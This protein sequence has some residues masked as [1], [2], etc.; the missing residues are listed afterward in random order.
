MALFDWRSWTIFNANSPS[1]DPVV[2]RRI[3]NAFVV[4]SGPNAKVLDV[5]GTEAGFMRRLDAIDRHRVC[6]VNPIKTR[7]IQYGFLSEVPDAEAPFALAMMFGVLMYMDTDQASATFKRTYELLAPGKSFMV[8]EPAIDTKLGAVDH[9]MRSKCG[10]PSRRYTQDAIGFLFVESGFVNMRSV[11]EYRPSV[12]WGN[13][14]WP[15]PYI[16]MIGDKPIV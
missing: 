9:V 14:H 13:I 5:G 6:A 8:A 3:W 15:Q 10:L 2:V 16:F 11:N 12:R 1:S 4:P 7:A